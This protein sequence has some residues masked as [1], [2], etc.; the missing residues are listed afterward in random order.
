MTSLVLSTDVTVLHTMALSHTR[1]SWQVLKNPKC[2]IIK[3]KKP[4]NLQRYS[5]T[6]KWDL[7]IKIQHRWHCGCLGQT[8]T[9]ELEIPLLSTHTQTVTHQFQLPLPL[10]QFY[11]TCYSI[12]LLGMFP[13]CRFSWGYGAVPCLSTH[14]AQLAARAQRYHFMSLRLGTIHSWHSKHLTKNKATHKYA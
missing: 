9:Y 14:C 3:T 10:H 8:V 4:L 11:L 2:L 1:M 5:N 7:L 6:L 12:D 13:S